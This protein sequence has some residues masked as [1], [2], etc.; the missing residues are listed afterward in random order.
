MRKEPEAPKRRKAHF[1]WWTL[2]N[3]LAGCLAILSWVLCLHI[4]GHPEIPKNYEILKKLDL[5]K[6]APGFVLQE[7]PPGDAADPRALYRRYAELDELSTARLNRGLI[8]N[9]LTELDEP[10]LIQYIEG[11]FE[12]TL[13]R[14]LSTSDLFHPGIAVRAR[15]M[16]QPDEFSEAAPWPVTI[17]YLFPTHD[18]TA[19]HWFRPGDRMAISKVPNCALLLHVARSE[20]DDTPLV[21]LTVAPVAMGKYQVGEDQS[22]IISTPPALNPRA[23]FPAFPEDEV[24]R[25]SARFRSPR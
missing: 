10:G 5:A 15:A 2:A 24:V 9:Y 12:I 17:D 23:P 13:V 6:P 25:S 22:F 4:F 21:R 7:A 3:V 16:V 19:I 8:R 20:H 11:D 14:E 18:T 1:Y